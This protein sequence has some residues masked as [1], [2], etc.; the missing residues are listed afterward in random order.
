MREKFMTGVFGTCPRLD[1]EKQN[2]L[3]IGTSDNLKIS[4]VKVNHLFSHIVLDVKISTNL[5][6]NVEILMV[7]FMEH[8]FH[9]YYYK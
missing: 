2:L 1:C 3:P 7:P 4:K 8:L 6:K 9:I 5:K